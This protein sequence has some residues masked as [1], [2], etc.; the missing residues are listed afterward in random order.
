M[1]VRHQ[2]ELGNVE[3]I[4]DP[5]L[6]KAYNIASMWKVADIAMYSVEPEAKHRPAMSEVVKELEDALFLEAQ[7]RQSAGPLC[8]TFSLTDKAERSHLEPVYKKLLNRE[9]KL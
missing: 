3:A 5:A 1:Q 2:L 7:G 6:N 4:V 8:T 9:D